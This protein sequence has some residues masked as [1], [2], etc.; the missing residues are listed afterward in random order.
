MKDPN[1]KK[2]DSSNFQPSIFEGLGVSFREATWCNRWFFPQKCY[3]RCEGW[4]LTH[5]PDLLT[6]DPIEEHLIEKHRGTLQRRG[7]GHLAWKNGGGAIWR[8]DLFPYT[9][10]GARPQ[11]LPNHKRCNS[12]RF[13]HSPLVFWKVPAGWFLGPPFR[14]FL[15]FGCI[16]PWILEGFS[17]KPQ[18]DCIWYKTMQYKF[19]YIVYIL[20]LYSYIFWLW[21]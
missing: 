2:K 13:I 7:S 17:W 10:L 19:N 3:P 16:K 1:L 9:K 8:G 20:P 21:L 6:Q 5:K 15:H 18:S 12:D 14:R 4:L 11:N